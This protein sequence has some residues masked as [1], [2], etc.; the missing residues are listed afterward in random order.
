MLKGLEDCQTLSGKCPLL[1]EGWKR[2]LQRVELQNTYEFTHLFQQILADSA[3]LSGALRMHQGKFSWQVS[4]RT[5]RS[6]QPD[7]EMT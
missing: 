7:T 6:M 3:A 4:L 1:L 5:S 2:Y